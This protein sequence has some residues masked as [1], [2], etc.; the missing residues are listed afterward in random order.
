M[1]IPAQ[2]VERAG[3][4]KNHFI[5][6]VDQDLPEKCVK[7]SLDFLTFTIPFTLFSTL[8]IY[9]GV[10]KRNETKRNK[11]KGMK[12]NETKRNKTKRNKTKR[13][14]FYNRNRNSKRNKYFSE[15]NRYETKKKFRFLIPDSELCWLIWKHIKDTKCTQ[16]CN[17]LNIP[18]KHE[19]RAS[20]QTSLHHDVIN[21]NFFLFFFWKFI[22]E[23][24]TKEIISTFFFQMKK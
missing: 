20:Q 19:A 2:M 24:S 22:I 1:W 18:K 13:Y 10:K 12:R 6:L 4:Q 21:D 8:C 9:I 16:S 23:N 5:V 7:V 14:F 15:T 11:T 3:Q 17:A